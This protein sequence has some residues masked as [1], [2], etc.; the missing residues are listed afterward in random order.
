MDSVFSEKKIGRRCDGYIEV[1]Y[2]G[3]KRKTKVESMKNEVIEFPDG[4]EEF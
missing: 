2:M 3:I 1:R 4:M